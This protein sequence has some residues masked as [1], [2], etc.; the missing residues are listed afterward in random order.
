M[1]YGTVNFWVAKPGVS[2]HLGVAKGALVASESMAE[3]V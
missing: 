3:T 2:P 1:E